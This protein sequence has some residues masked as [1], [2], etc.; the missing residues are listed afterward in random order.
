MSTSIASLAEFERCLRLMTDLAA[1]LRKQDDHPESISR[2]LHELTDIPNLAELPSLLINAYKELNTA[3]G[4]VAVRLGSMAAQY[5]LRDTHKKLDEVSSTTESAATEI[6]NGLDR[7]L[8]KVENMVGI[9]QN[10]NGSTGPEQEQLKALSEELRAEVYQM[11][12][13]LQFQDITSQQIQG[14]MELLGDADRKLNSLSNLFEDNEEESHDNHKER[15]EAGYNPDATMFG[16]AERQ[17][18][19]D[20]TIQ[21]IR[22]SDETPTTAAG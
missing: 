9:T 10:G 1:E 5:Q 8:E 6:L 11:F 13:L 14:A 18:V 22:N 16:V 2:I 20:E 21:S 19:V 7:T 3:I 15:T 12:N 17:A 4:G